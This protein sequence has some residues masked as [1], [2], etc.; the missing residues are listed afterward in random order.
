MVT[1]QPVAEHDVAENDADAE[2][3]GLEQEPRAENAGAQADWVAVESIAHTGAVVPTVRNIARWKPM[4]GPSAEGAPE[5]VDGGIEFE[6]EG[7][8]EDG[9]NDTLGGDEGREG[10][11]EASVGALIDGGRELGLHEPVGGAKDGAND[12]VGGGVAEDGDSELK[13]GGD[14]IELVGPIEDVGAGAGANVGEFEKTGATAKISKKQ[15]LVS[16]DR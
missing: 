6:P 16:K 9:A 1:L 2:P 15:N 14:V 12:R 3:Q 8:T 13:V 7:E 5:D 4:G 11:S 10:A